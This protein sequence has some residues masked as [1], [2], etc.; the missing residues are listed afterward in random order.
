MGHGIS[1]IHGARRINCSYN[2]RP[3][4]PDR[5]ALFFISQGFR[6]VIPFYWSGSIL[7]IFSDKIA[8]A[9]SSH[10]K[11]LIKYNNNQSSLSVSIVAK[12]GGAIIAEKALCMISA[13]KKI[14][15]GTF[16]TFLR[17]AAPDARTN[18]NASLFNNTVNIISSQDWLYKLMKF[19]TTAIIKASIPNTKHIVRCKTYKIEGL[20]HGDFNEN[21]KINLPKIFQGNVY[22]FYAKILKDNI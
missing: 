10:L 7:D 11:K 14:D 8:R 1:I 5:L 21:I 13:R 12:S 20:K 19:P 22:D 4:W 9:Y 17:I 16:S 15:F 2:Y 6:P 3:N 18:I